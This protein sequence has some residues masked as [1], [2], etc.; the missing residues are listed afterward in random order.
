MKKIM[1]KV[2][3]QNNFLYDEKEFKNALTI[4]G[5]T[6]I[7]PNA[8]KVTDTAQDCGVQIVST[9]DWHYLTSSELSDNPDF[10]ETYPLHC[11]AH[12]QGAEIIDELKPKNPAIV[13]WDQSYKNLDNLVNEQEI[14]IRK[15]KFDVFEGNLNTENLIKTLNPNRVIVYGVATNVCVDQAVTGLR[16][17]V[18]E[19]YVIKDAIHGLPDNMAKK[20]IDQTI[21]EWEKG[22]NPIKFVDSN[23]FV[24]YLR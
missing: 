17:M 7:I 24:D 11:L 19:V 20:T 10:N 18:D 16:K 21:T 5:A 23:N 14:V 6:D 1:W 9:M 22:N 8:K 13:E 2:D 4:P 15:D 12:T 3:M